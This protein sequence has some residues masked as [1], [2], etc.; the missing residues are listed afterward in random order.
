MSEWA[1]WVEILLGFNLMLKVSAFYLEKKSFI[2]KKIFFHW[3]CC[4]NSQWR[5]WFS[6]QFER[7]ENCFC[8]WKIE[9]KE[10]IICCFCNLRLSVCRSIICDQ[11]R[12]HIASQHQLLF[13]GL[14]VIIWSKYFQIR[15]WISIMSNL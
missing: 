7:I 12:W 4:P 15:I 3:A 14:F 11:T 13:G 6:G 10:R 8:V 9:A 2:E 1:E 5:F